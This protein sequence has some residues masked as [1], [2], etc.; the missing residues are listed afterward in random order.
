MNLINKNDSIFVAGNTG[1][2]GTA[3]KKEL[4]KN[5][6]KNLLLPN[7][8]DLDLLEYNSVKKWFN[9]NKPQ[10]VI[11]AAAKVGGIEVNSKFPADFILENLKIQTNVIENAWR[12]SVKKFIF[13]GSSCIYPKDA[14]QPLKEEY[15]LS[16]PLEIT[17]EAYAIAK[18]AGLKLCTSLN[19]QYDFGAINLMPTNLYGPGD[20]YDEMS[21]HVMP[22]LIRKIYYAKKNNL[23]EIICW[24]SGKPKREFLHV[25][26]LARAVLFV[27]ENIDSNNHLLKDKNNFYEGILNIG[28]GHDISIEELVE[29]ICKKL[30]YK[31]GILW[32]KE[33]PDGTFKKQLDVSKIKEMGWESAINLED[34]ISQTIDSFINEKKNKTLRS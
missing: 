25:S 9:A 5:N 1:M 14:P 27:L 11:L 6:Y 31:G 3:I 30:E 24:G 10:I 19:R 32:D 33:K 16:G 34:G 2:V 23:P 8:N 15:L 12:N 20:N 21:S 26:D 17:N 22:A 4:L 29:I 7:R 28:T 13:L 18:I